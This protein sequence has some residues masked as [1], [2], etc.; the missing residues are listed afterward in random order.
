MDLD[1]L[2]RRS[3]PG[4]TSP[5]YPGPDSGLLRM[6]A[7]TNL[8]GR[9]PAVERAAR[10]LPEID[11]NQDPSGLSDALREALAREHGLSREEVLVG[12]GSDEVLDVVCKTFVNPDDVVAVPSPSFVMY[13]FFGRL[14]LARLVE[15][16]LLRPGWDLDVD[17]ILRARAKVAFVASPNN[18]TGN[19][20]PP[21]DLERLVRD[22]EGIVVVDEAYADFCGQDFASRVG[23]FENLV[24]SRTFSKSHGLA[25]LR[26]GYGLANR[27]L[28]GKLT[29]AKTPLTMGAIGEA[30]ALEAL[31]DKSF[32]RQG[33]AIVRRERERLAAA[34]AAIGLRPARTDANFMILDVGEPAR[35]A[36]A[37]LR[38]KG[39]LTR[40]MGDFAGMENF[41]R[42]TVG[43]PEHNDRLVAALAEWKRARGGAGP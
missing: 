26:V 38:G 6:D 25:G 13:A 11:L 39:I 42:A 8:I 14:H 1:R 2:L 5:G 12:A 17:A 27:R 23:R 36:R 22:S 41:I 29:A 33:V 16:P 7:N 35:G 37:F 18:P 43:R 24:V 20:F 4:L 34:C 10:R 3:V 31:A 40:D 30:V 28:M 19:A 21:E 32:H 15:I 9:N